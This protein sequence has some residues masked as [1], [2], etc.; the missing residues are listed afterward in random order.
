MGIKNLH[1]LLQ[2]YAP[3][4]YKTCH[5]SEYSF[6]KVA[7]DISLYLYKYKAVY[8]DRW[9]EA[10][11]SLVNCLRKWDVHCIFVYDSKA[12]VEKVEEQKRRA[13]N[14]VKQV[15]KIKAL[16]KEIE[17]F[18]QSG[19]VGEIISDISK[20]EGIIS[21]FRN[22]QIVDISVVKNKLES[23]KNMVISVSPDDLL[24][25]Q[26]LF[27]MLKV[28]YIKAPSE[29]EA[30]AS[31]LC[32][33]QKVDAVLSE[34]TDVL[35]YGTPIFL[36]KIDTNKDTVV[37]LKYECILE[38]IGMN[39]ESF[40]DLCIMCGCDYNDN[41]KNIGPE[42]S[43]SLLR[44]YKTIEKVLEDLDA[45]LDKDGNKKYDTTI[46]KYQRCR[47]LFQ[48]PEVDFYVSYCGMPDFKALQEFLFKNSIRYSIDILKKNLS[49][50]DLIFEE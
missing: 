8:G 33:N 50:R 32:V 5:L 22:K 7:I 11:I 26:Q 35:A 21:L 4:C 47:E 17:E 18:E 46:L 23:M 34:D 40:T 15:D 41:I 43:I 16:E 20:K 12:P 1:K 36:T 27:D 30:Y 6:K 28:P 10:F 37:E 38:E 49:P 31:H 24:L 19:K 45:Q 39:K 29:A 3:N 42:K 2:K 9:I 48:V 14:R 25:S 44:N 13:E